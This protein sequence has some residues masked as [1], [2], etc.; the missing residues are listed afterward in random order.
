MANKE[1]VKAIDFKSREVYRSSKTPGYTAWASFFPGERG[2]W[3]LTCEEVSRPDIPLPQCTLEQSYEMAHPVGYDKSQYL[4]EAVI[5]ESTDDMQTWNEISRQPYHHHHSV[6]QFATARTTDG[7][8]LRFIWAA[9]SLDSSVKTNEIFYTSDDNGQTWKKEPPFQDEH[10]FGYAHRL[11][12]LRDGTM[13]LALPLGSKW[14]AGEELP[15][16]TCRDLN[17]IGGHQMTLWFSY[18]QG[19]TWDGPLPIYAGETVSETDFVELPEG[20]LLCINNSIFANPGRQIIYRD[21]Q[22]WTPGPME[23]AKNAQRVPVPEGVKPWGP[24]SVPETVCLTED[25]ILV[26]CLR[27]SSYQW[28]DDLGL[29]WQPLEG[30]PDLTPEMYQPWI[31]YLGDGRIVCSGHYGGDNPV[32]SGK[33]VDQYLMLHEFSINVRHRTQ[34]AKVDIERDF[35]EKRN[36]WPNAYTLTLT[37][38]G[39]PLEN[40]EV[41][42]WYVMGNAPGYDSWNSIPLD[43]RMALGGSLVKLSTD[44][45]GKARLVMPELDGVEDPHRHYQLVARFN[46]DRNDI[47]YKPAQSAQFNQYCKFQRDPVL[48]ERA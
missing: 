44:S 26:G 22:R 16:R 23:R 27:T 25:G 3:Y 30:A 12:T 37:T 14:G 40:K 35:D 28:S 43:N 33:V 17:A 45:E 20:H 18:D 9:Y 7:R 10:F 8:F 38:D 21:G 29:S 19:R 31:Y 24:N 6:H 15:L 48:E 11:R 39:R 46:A 5:L 41:E 36:L 32:S 4:M 2:Q 1:A 34:T 47:D 13:V 42:V